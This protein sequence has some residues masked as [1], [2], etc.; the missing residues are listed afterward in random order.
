MSREDPSKTEKATPKRRNKA[1][2]K[3]SVPRSQEVS[4]VVSLL[5]GAGILYFMIG[6]L[7]AEM[8]EVFVWF[9]HRDYNM[10][11]NQSAVNGMFLLVLERLA[12]MLLPILFFL[13]ALAYISIRLQVG[14]LWT[15]K[16]FKFDFSKMINP[17]QGMQKL[18]I[19]P[20]TF[21][22]LFKQ[23]GQAVAIGFAPYM[24]L[25][26]EFNNFLPLF[27]QSPEGY[28]VYILSAGFKMVMYAMIPMLLIAAAD[29]W[30]T[31]WSYEDQL[32]MTKDEVKD[33]RKQAEGDPVVRSKQRQK[34]LQMMQ[35]RMLESVPKADVI[36]TNPTHYACALQYNPMV[37]PAPLLLAKG[38]DH[39]AEKIKEIARE[40]NIPI[41]ENKPLAQ[42]LYKSVEIGDIIPEELYQAV[43]GI[44]AQLNK[45]K[46][47]PR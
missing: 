20:Q 23:V 19:S 37:A 33:E 7:N 17:M 1:R 44:L 27:Y 22:R 28:A 38:V 31:R 18:F 4:K 16:V 30:Y 26:N 41:R 29:L 13:A 35:K 6:Y 12:I 45:F 43:A 5:G 40:N 15:L 21:F 42:A 32:K 11:L 9:L 24:L 46:R 36:I 34:M 14:A 3:G 39:L 25:K 8:Q 47:G 10:D 2:D